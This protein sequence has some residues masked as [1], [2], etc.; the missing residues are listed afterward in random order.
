MRYRSGSGDI[1]EPGEEKKKK[2]HRKMNRTL[3]A[4]VRAQRNLFWDVLHPIGASE[5]KHGRW[6][7]RGFHVRD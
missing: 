7:A 5:R 6:L 3:P 2:K 4:D 1:W